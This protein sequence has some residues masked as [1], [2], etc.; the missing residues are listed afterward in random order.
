MLDSDL[1]ALLGQKVE[2]I[3]CDGRATRKGHDCPSTYG[4]RVPLK[5]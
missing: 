1:E 3:T 5:R 4:Q 2:R